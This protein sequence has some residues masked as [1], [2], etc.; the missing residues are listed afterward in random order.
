MKIYKI[1]DRYVVSFAHARKIAI[2]KGLC[3]ED[4]QPMTNRITD[5]EMG[6]RMPKMIRRRR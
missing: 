1:A 5:K 3:D 6:R 2:R 4:I